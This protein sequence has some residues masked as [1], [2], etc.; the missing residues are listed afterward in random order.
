[1][2]PSFSGVRLVKANVKVTQC[3][4][5]RR[6]PQAQDPANSAMGNS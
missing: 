6:Y 2:N 3:A 5:P 1:M 4:G